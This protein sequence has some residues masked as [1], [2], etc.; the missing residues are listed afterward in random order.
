MDERIGDLYYNIQGEG[1]SSH[2]SSENC[3]NLFLKE[4]EV[5]IIHQLSQQI[6]QFE[7][8][9]AQ[10]SD[11]CAELDLYVEISFLPTRRLIYS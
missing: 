8:S 3:N 4:R 5:E 6:L 7:D 10:M 1:V 11:I 9:L 2:L